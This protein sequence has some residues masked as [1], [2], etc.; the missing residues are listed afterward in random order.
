[1]DRNFQSKAVEKNQAFPLVYCRMSLF[2][3]ILN[4]NVVKAKLTKHFFKKIC[5]FEFLHQDSL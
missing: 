5:A 1:M 4:G 3:M 2:D